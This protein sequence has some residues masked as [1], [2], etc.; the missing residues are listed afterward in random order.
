MLNP[1]A[2][3]RLQ[4]GNR[5]YQNPQPLLSSGLLGLLP[6]Q[7]PNVRGIQGD[8]SHAVMLVL[9]SLLSSTLPHQEEPKASNSHPGY[10][11]KTRPV[12]PMGKPSLVAVKASKCYQLS[13]EDFDDIWKGWCRT[14]PRLT[15]KSVR[16][17]CPPR[18]GPERTEDK[19]LTQAGQTCTAAYKGPGRSI[20]LSSQTF[21]TILPG[22]SREQPQPKGLLRARNAKIWDRF[23][24]QRPMSCRRLQGLQLSLPHHQTVPVQIPRLDMLLALALLPSFSFTDFL[25]R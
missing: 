22:S 10:A 20:R 14:S 16:N 7:E 21:K 8:Q 24:F 9:P 3:H 13:T 4:A 11:A 6:D 17:V 5:H 18:H 19:E 23:S 15:A 25:S 1:P 12:C 2:Q